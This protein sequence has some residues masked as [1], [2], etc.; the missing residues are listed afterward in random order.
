MKRIKT[1]AAFLIA[2]TSILACSVSVFA[3]GGHHGGY[4]H[5]YGYGYSN[6]C[7][8]YGNC[9][10]HQNNCPNYGHYGHC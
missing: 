1:T 2:L 3:H 4:G 9:Y 10:Y 5:N 8:N 7:P 6:P